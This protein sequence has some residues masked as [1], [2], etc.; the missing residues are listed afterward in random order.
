MAATG[1]AGLCAGFLHLP[2]LPEQAARH[3]G[4]PG[5]APATM[6]AALHAVL[7]A[8]RDSPGPDAAA[9]V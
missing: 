4:Q 5:M 2:W 9:I 7:A 1:H 8:V 6:L 3:G